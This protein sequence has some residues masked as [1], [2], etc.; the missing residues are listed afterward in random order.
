M[1]KLL[2]Q[3][4][5]SP[6]QAGETARR[7]L[8]V[9]DETAI[10]SFYSYV[11]A[12][13]GYEVDRAVDGDEGWKM[14]QKHSYDLLITDQSMPG[15]SGT[16]LFRNVRA[17]GMELPVILA[18]GVTPV[19]DEGLPFDAIL[20][21]PFPAIKLLQMVKQVLGETLDDY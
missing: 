16:E 11:L 7:V 1:E 12:S 2:E 5:D 13:E 18:T 9:D 20:V 10:L 15:L 19:R 21:K 14:L 3:D 6:S 8:V 17:K 4:V